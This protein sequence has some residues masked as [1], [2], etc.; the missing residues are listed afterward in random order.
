[1]LFHTSKKFLSK[2][3]DVSNPRET[4]WGKAL[5]GHEY[6]RMIANECE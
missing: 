3:N 5:V 4:A 1:M 6:L 2:G